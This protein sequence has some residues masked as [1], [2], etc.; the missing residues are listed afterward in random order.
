[1][2]FRWG[3]KGYKEFRGIQEVQRNAGVLG[4]YRGLEEY[5]GFKSMQVVQEYTYRGF[6]SIHVVFRGLQGGQ[7]N[8]GGLE[9]QRG[10]GR[11][12]EGQR[13]KKSLYEPLTNIA[14]TLCLNNLRF[15]CLFI[16][17]NLGKL[18]NIC[19]HYRVENPA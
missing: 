4:V 9:E 11:I 6:R 7:R 5:N 17:R 14:R 19:T 16:S 18:R 12:Q 15:P 13:Y 2:H 3:F 1:M 8:T 10:F